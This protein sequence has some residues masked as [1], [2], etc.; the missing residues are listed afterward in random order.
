MKF[1]CSRKSSGQNNVHNP[2]SKPK[3]KFAVILI[4]NLKN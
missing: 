3:P 2:D 1:L 4:L